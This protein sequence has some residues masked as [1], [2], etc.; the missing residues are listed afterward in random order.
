MPCPWVDDED[1]MIKK[2]VIIQ[3]SKLQELSVEA[4][5]A[6]RISNQVEAGETLDFGPETGFSLPDP[7]DIG[8]PQPTTQETFD[9][10]FKDLIVKVGVKTAEEF[11]TECAKAYDTTL[12]N[13][14]ATAIQDPSDFERN[15]LKY[16]AQSKKLQ[17]PK[18]GGD[19][20]DDDQD[21]LFAPFKN[22]RTDGFKKKVEKEIQEILK[23]PVE[24]QN[25]I[26]QKWSKYLPNVPFP[27]PEEVESAPPPP[28]QQPPETGPIENL[29]A[30][31]GNQGT[32]QGLFSDQQ[33]PE[34]EASEPFTK[35]VNIHLAYL[36]PEKVKIIIGTDKPQDFVGDE[37]RQNRALELLRM[38]SDKRFANEV[39]AY[40]EVLGPA[41]IQEIIGEQAVDATLVPVEQRFNAIAQLKEAVDLAN[42]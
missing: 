34:P 10:K 22:L 2:T 14:M 13:V 26:R 31:A 11:L 12:D 8:K 24:T 20:G 42:A 5:E 37:A 4:H 6:I 7:E 18:Q 16:A 17:Q 29:S 25:K 9:E 15:L 32:D 33:K 28:Q 3:G 38:S 27:Q 19:D 1:E 40:T 41:K 36:G 39:A 23:Y 30:D 21:E 35:M